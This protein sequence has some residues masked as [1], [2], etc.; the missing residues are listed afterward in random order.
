[1]HLCFKAIIQS[2]GPPMNYN[3][4]KKNKKQYIDV[5]IYN[6]YFIKKFFNQILYAFVIFGRMRSFSTGVVTSN[7]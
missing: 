2:E 7:I 6:I 3:K 1:M 4:Q 5:A